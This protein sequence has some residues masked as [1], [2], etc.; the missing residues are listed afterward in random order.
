[1]AKGHFWSA[2]FFYWPTLKNHISHTNMNLWIL[3]KI[4]HKYG[5]FGLHFHMRIGSPWSLSGSRQ[6]QIH[7]CILP[8]S[9]PP[10]LICFAFSH[11]LSGPLMDLNLETLNHTLPPPLNP[12]LWLHVPLYF[13]FNFVPLS[14]GSTNSFISTVPKLDSLSPFSFFSSWI[15]LLSCLFPPH[16]PQ[17]FLLRSWRMPL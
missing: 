9:P 8:R 4:S 5:I 14:F 7:K 6:V 2:N 11:C 12:A 15:I 1:M 17:N 3:L 13:P 10:H 16:I